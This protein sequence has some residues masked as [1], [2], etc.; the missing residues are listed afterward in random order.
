MAKASI[1]DFQVSNTRFAMP[2]ESIS[3]DDADVDDLD[4]ADEDQEDLDE[5]A[6]DLEDENE[7]DTDDTDVADTDEAEDEESTED[8]EE[9]SYTPFVSDLAADGVL[10]IVDGKDYDDSPEGLKEIIQDT[11]SSR[12]STKVATLPPTAQ[13]LWELAEKGATEEDIQDYL[14]LDNGPDWEEADLEDEDVQAAIVEE[15]LRLRDP[16]ATDEDIEE[17]VADLRDLGKLEK[18]AA[19]DQKFLIKQQDLQKESIGKQVE[20]R[21]AEQLENYKKEVTKVKNFIEETKEIAG[22]SLTKKDREDFLAYLTVK[23]KDGLTQSD[24]MNTY[25]RR[26][27]KEFLNFKNFN[28]GK[29]KQ[30]AVTEATKEV[31]KELSRYNKTVR[32]NGATRPERRE[33]FGGRIILPGEFNQE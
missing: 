3:V 24:K 17:A 21:Q 27:Q 22:L 9:F 7:V 28:L 6:Q 29:L 23:D 10:T 18:Q 20:Q 5:D 25:E 19:K 8:E 2:G 1:K 32:N 4:A 16:E 13:K 31:R 11:V 15:A 26:I 30:Q 33:A 12:I 14:T